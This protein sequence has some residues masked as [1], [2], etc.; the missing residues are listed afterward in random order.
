MPSTTIAA[1]SDREPATAAI[2]IIGDEVGNADKCIHLRHTRTHT[3]AHLGYLLEPPHDR[4]HI[5][6]TTVTLQTHAPTFIALSHDT[7]PQVH[8][9]SEV[10]THHMLSCVQVLSGHVKDSNAHF[11]ARSCTLMTTA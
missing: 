6:P 7:C 1:D 3:H 5:H 11:L 10:L 4:H 2:V 8:S 9:H